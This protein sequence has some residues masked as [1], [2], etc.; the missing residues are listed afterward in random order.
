M[1]GVRFN[2]QAQAA[3]KLLEQRAVCIGVIAPHMLKGATSVASAF[4]PLSFARMPPQCYSDPVIILHQERAHMIEIS[5]EY[6]AV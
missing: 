5:I 2:L 3:D 1:G 6:C 4:R